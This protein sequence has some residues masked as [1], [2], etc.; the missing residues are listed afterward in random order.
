MMTNES[1]SILFITDSSSFVVKAK[2]ISYIQKIVIINKEIQSM[3]KI[4]FKNF[5]I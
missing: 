4:L 1:L 2:A 3:F 5:K